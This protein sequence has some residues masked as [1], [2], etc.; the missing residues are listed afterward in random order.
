MKK[1]ILDIYGADA[2]EKEIICGAAKTI[3]AYP[4]IHIVL[5]G[6]GKIIT[7]IMDENSIPSDRYS[8]L[9]TDEYVTNY[10]MP[11]C[12][13]TNTNYSMV[14]ALRYLRDNEDCLGLLSAGNTGALLVGTICHLGLIKGLKYP[15]LSAHINTISDKL[16]CIVDCG[17]NLECTAKDLLRFAIMGNVIAG[18][19]TFEDNPKVALLSVGSE[20]GKGTSVI[21]DAF[22][23][24][25]DCEK[26]NFVGN[27]EGCNIMDNTADVIVCDGYAGNVVLKNTEETG[28]TCVSLIKEMTKDIADSESRKVVDEITGKLTDKFDFNSQ[29]GA[30]F[31]GTKK[32]VIKMHGIA[33]SD[34][35]VSCVSQLITLENNGFSQ[36]ISQLEL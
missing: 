15:A 25:R 2:G 31:L 30:T 20:E 29:G 27:I 12:V 34:T 1:I 23:L 4:D 21:K 32:T 7:E 36:K 5:A 26:I 24:I 6:D 11:T 18:C 19:R 10:D 22:S 35:V 13:F 9:H 33:N 8:V 16:V 3:R 14:K 28:K 17:A